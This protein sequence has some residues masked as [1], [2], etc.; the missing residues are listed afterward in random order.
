M[1]SPGGPACTPDARSCLLRGRAWCKGSAGPELWLWGCRDRSRPHYGLQ[2]RS[3]VTCRAPYGACHARWLAAAAWEAQGGYRARDEPAPPGVSLMSPCAHTKTRTQLK[4][5]NS[6][7]HS[8]HET[9]R[10]SFRTSV[11]RTYFYLQNK[12]K[13]VRRYNRQRRIINWQ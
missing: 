2:R 3:A 1:G 11:R 4:R 6:L 9:K 8:G 13:S 5:P 12:Y 10:K 7:R